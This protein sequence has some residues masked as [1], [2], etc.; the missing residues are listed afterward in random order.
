[1]SPYFW[2][3]VAVCAG[4][5]LFIGI[6]ALLVIGKARSLERRVRALQTH[7][8]LLALRQAQSISEQVQR[9]QAPM[10]EIRARLRRIAERLAEMGE[11]AA[12]MDL[13]VGRMTFATRML[14]ETFVPTLRGSMAD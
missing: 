1:M 6:S 11:A 5:G 10:S 14:L 3:G 2:I 12:L 9:L 7:P 8:A 13:D 4:T